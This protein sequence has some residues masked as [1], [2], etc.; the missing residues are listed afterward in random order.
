MLLV[1]G[2]GSGPWALPANL[3]VA[4][5][6]PVVTVLGTLAA[7]LGPVW[8]DGAV[9]LAAACGPALWWLE[10]VANVAAGLPGSPAQE[11]GAGG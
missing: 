7:A 1:A 8:D 4:P 5:V 10:T 3:A 6:V 11:G 2:M 9:V